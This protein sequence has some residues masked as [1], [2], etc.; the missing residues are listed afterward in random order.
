MKF[1]PYIWTV[2]VNL[3]TLFVVFS[4]FS[5]VYGS[6]ETIVISMLVLIYVGLVTSTG[7]AGQTKMQEIL[8]VHEEFKRLRKILKEEQTEDEVEF[9]KEDVESA[10]KQM[11]KVQIK[12][13]INAGF[14]TIIFITAIL[15][16]LGAL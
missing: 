11:K 3:I 10:K 15:N 12:F 4:I 14:N 7:A 6:F 8:L 5:S 13:Y 1:I 2:V 16:L 9:E